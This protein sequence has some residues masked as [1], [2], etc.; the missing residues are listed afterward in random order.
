MASSH[1]N[2]APRATVIAIGLSVVFLVLAGLGLA[3]VHAL[4][5]ITAALAAGIAALAAT[6][7]V[8]RG[9]AEWTTRLDPFAIAGVL[10]FVVAS[11][12]AVRYS[13]VS[14]TTH[15]DGASSLAVWAYPAGD[16]L[17]VGMRQPPGRRE[18]SLRVVVSQEGTTARAWNNVRLAPGQ[19]WE[20]PPL[21][22]TGTGSVRVVV[23]SAGTVVASVSAAR[24]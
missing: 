6:W 23:L 18:A 8:A 14:A 5:D 9:K 19:T 1:D 3:A 24:D 2:S 21:T 12:L 22:L 13:A 16:R 11:V 10:V 20:A 7:Y 15:A 4:N 17:Q